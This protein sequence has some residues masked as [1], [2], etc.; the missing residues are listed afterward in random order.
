[1]ANRI[2]RIAGSGREEPMAP[3]G[4]HRVRAHIRRNPRPS[5]KKTSGWMIAGVVAVL[6]LWGHF[7]GFSDGNATTPVNSNPT[8]SAPAGR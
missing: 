7:I 1:M 2:E 3:E 4:Y 8:V 6:W 5:A